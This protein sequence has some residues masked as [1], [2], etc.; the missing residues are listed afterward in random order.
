MAIAYK[1]SL[2]QNNWKKQKKNTK[3]DVIFMLESFFI[4]FCAK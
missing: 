4:N 3:Q 2:N 1:H